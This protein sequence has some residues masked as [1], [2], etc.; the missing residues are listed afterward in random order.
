VITLF[1]NKSTKRT[2]GSTNNH[3]NFRIYRP[4]VTPRDEVHFI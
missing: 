2:E 3:N 1:L 4:Y